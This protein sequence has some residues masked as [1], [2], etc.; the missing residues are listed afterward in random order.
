M[1]KIILVSVEEYEGDLSLSC[2]CFCLERV[3]QIISTMLTI[4]SVW[5]EGTR[6]SLSSYT[7]ASVWKE[8]IRLSLPSYTYCFC[9]ERVDQIISIKL[10]V[11]LLSGKSGSDYLYQ[12]IR[13][14][15]VWKEWIRLSLSSYTYCFCLERVDQIISIKLY[16]LLLSGKS[17]SEYLYHAIRI[18]SVWKEWIRLSLSRYTYC[19][20]LERVDQIISITLYVLLLSGKSGSDYLYQA[21]RIAS[22]WKEWIRLSLSSYT[23]CFC[24]ERVDQIISTKLY[25]LLLS[26]KSGSDYLYHAI[27]IASVWKE[28]IRLSLSSYTYCF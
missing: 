20:C 24:L 11:L 10:Y 25:V 28:W 14:A 13:I 18:A 3:D 1:M 21:I 7:I 23:Y 6:L 22:V 2:Y 19:F 4:A 17:G 15:S 8:W 26:G 16:V 27:R 9:L 5:K 12:A